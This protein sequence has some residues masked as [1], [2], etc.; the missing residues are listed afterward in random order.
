MPHLAT[1][2]LI[3]VW[4]YINYCKYGK[5]RLR[6]CPI[7][8]EQIIPTGQLVTAQQILL[9][10]TLLEIQLELEFKTTTALLK[11]ARAMVRIESNC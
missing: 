9:W 6:E 7:S 2:F 8:L 3:V 4:P 5:S 10:V 1:L 11:Y